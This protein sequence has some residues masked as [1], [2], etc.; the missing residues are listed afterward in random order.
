MNTRSPWTWVPTLFGAEEIPSAM[1]TFV[2]LLMFLQCGA[3]PVRATC[4]S[5]LLF[6]PWTLKSF[7]RSWVRQRGHFRHT[8]HWLEAL[9]FLSLVL[10][11]LSFPYGQAALF[12]SLMLTSMLCA[13]HELA[14]RMYYERMLRP[15][16][17]RVFTSPKIFFSQT[18]VVLTYGMLII[19]V[20]SLQ[21]YYR[22]I[23]HAWST[24]C[25]LLAGVFALFALYHL[26]ALRSPL[27]GNRSQSGGVG[28]SV[29][30]EMHIIERIQ[31]Q[32]GWLA[33]VVSLVFLLLPQSLMF[34]TRVIY[35][36]ETRARGGLGCSIQEI[37]FAQGTVGVMAFCLGLTLGRRILLHTSLSKAFWPLGIVLGLSPLAYLYMSLYPPTSLWVIC[38]CTSLAQFCFGLGLF[39][40]RLP[41]RYISGERYRNTINLLYI[42][43]VATCLIPPAALS[44]WLSQLCGYRLFFLIDALTAPLAWIVTLIAMRRCPVAFGKRTEENDRSIPSR[45]A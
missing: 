18:A 8:L 11:A 5:A 35:L 7:I 17:Q 37:G 24:G 26:P 15:P 34:F 22:H 19:V 41:V 39:A 13:C 16:L 2:A 6:L 12:G 45:K 1:V 36:Y 42:P 31:R 3:S 40:C 27:V 9:L 4:Y 21:V 23:R 25:Y 30:A 10:V 32:P 33:P 20:G 43:L 14:A 38:V 28:H 29:R 44:G